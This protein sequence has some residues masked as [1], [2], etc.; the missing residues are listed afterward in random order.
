VAPY[1]RRWRLLRSTIQRPISEQL[2]A[3]SQSHVTL[4]LRL[5]YPMEPF[6]FVVE[7]VTR[8]DISRVP[9]VTI[10]RQIAGL[11][12]ATSQQVAPIIPRCCCRLARFS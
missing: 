4:I 2:Q 3:V 8:L 1:S 7:Q 6:L 12:P 9:N 10:R 11:P 5:S